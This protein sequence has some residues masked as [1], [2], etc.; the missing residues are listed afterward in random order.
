MHKFLLLPLQGQLPIAC[1]NR[2]D[3]LSSLLVNESLGLLCLLPHHCLLVSLLP[4]RSLELHSLVSLDGT[5]SMSSEL[6][7]VALNLKVLLL[8]CSSETSLLLLGVFI[9]LVLKLVGFVCNLL[10]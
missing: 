1:L 9:N 7:C 8:G 2:T 10:E 6:G 4:L 5:R 3:G